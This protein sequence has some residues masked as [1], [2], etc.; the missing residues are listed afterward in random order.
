MDI[1][2]IGTLLVAGA[3][4][5]A[6][7]VSVLEM[8]RQR[9]ND[10]KPVLAVIEKTALDKDTGK[11]SLH[12]FLVNMGR[13]AA[14]DVQVTTDPPDLVKKPHQTV[15][16]PNRRIKLASNYEPEVLP[17]LKLEAEYSDLDG[18]TYLD[19]ILGQQGAAERWRGA[20]CHRAVP[21]EGLEAAGKG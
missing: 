1:Y 7:I 2:S 20:A 10:I 17:S 3:A 12:L 16:A 19:T 5:I 4:L 21:S 8:R 11:R 14:L 9:R 6:S 13:A 15:V 18:T